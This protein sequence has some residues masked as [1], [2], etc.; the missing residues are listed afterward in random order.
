VVAAARVNL[1]R[2]IKWKKRARIVTKNGDEVFRFDA[3]T[4][5]AALPPGDYIIEIDDNRI[6][7]NATE[8]QVLDVNPQ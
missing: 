7:F 3:V 8:G 2:R 6:P 4:Y 5:R 1:D